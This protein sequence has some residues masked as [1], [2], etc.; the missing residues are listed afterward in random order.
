MRLLTQFAQHRD[1]CRECF[2]SFH[3]QRPDGYC[4]TG[5]DILKELAA[6]PEVEP[7]NEKNPGT[8]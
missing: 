2:R 6:Q 4:P 3:A 8:N 5:T 1:G 7:M